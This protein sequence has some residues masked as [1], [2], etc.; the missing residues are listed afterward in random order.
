MLQTVLC[1]E[2]ICTCVDEGGNF[3]KDICQHGQVNMTIWVISSSQFSY[4]RTA[5]VE[6]WMRQYET[7]MKTQNSADILLCS[8]VTMNSKIADRWVLGRGM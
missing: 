7:I 5:S 8:R 4:G 3:F 6:S 2:W 1:K